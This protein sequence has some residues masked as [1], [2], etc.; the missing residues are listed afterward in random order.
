M[1]CPAYDGEVARPRPLRASAQ[2]QWEQVVANP[3]QS[4]DAEPGRTR[5]TRRTGRTRQRVVLV[6]VARLGL[7]AVPVAAVG[8]V[9]VRQNYRR[10]RRNLRAV[11]RPD[12]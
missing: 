9:R 6:A 1:T 2:V 8:A 10:Q 3:V 7:V 4:S 5:S 12:H 11:A